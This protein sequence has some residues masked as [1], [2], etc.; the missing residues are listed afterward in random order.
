MNDARTYAKA[1]RCLMAP[2]LFSAEW[3]PTQKHKFSQCSCVSRSLLVE[4]TGSSSKLGESAL[5]QPCLSS[6][7]CGFLEQSLA[8]SGLSALIF[9][10]TRSVQFAMECRANVCVP[11][12]FP[13]HESI[14]HSTA[15]TATAG[16]IE[17]SEGIEGKMV[18]RKL[19]MV[20]S[21]VR[22]IAQSLLPRNSYG[23]SRVI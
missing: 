6:R 12:I 19:Q 3:G 22:A 1:R 18:S 17:E 4:F 8:P 5:C 15:K 16:E 20:S 10:S 7:E 14:C 13:K 2:M 21:E 11:A 9:G 23:T